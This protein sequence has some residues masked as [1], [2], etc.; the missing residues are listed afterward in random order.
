M[1]TSQYQGHDG[2]FISFRSQ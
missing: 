1:K 2:R